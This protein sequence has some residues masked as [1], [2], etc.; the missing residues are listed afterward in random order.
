MIHEVQFGEEG[1]T[2]ESYRSRQLLGNKVVP[3]VSKQLVR[4]GIVKSYEGAQRLIL[5]CIVICF[6]LAGVVFFF[7]TPGIRLHRTP[8]VLTNF[9]K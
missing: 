5:A 2:N 6:L 4:L 1:E 7:L 8:E 9:D 3:G